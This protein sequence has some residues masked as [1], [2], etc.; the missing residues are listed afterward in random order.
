MRGIVV[1]PAEAKDWDRAI[2][3]AWTTFRQIATQVCDEEGVGRFKDGLIGTQLYIDFL[4]GKYPLFGAYQGDRM[5]GML[6]LK[7]D[8]HIS[9]LF[10]KREFQGS[11]VGTEL[12][13]VCKDYCKERGISELTVNAAPTGLPFYL[14]QGF[15]ALE[16]EKFEGGMRFTPMKLYIQR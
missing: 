8:S 12:L 9:L 5:V 15:L 11:G 7:G 4:Q 14:A 6:L 2:A 3:L 16:G 1:K 10:V 13:K